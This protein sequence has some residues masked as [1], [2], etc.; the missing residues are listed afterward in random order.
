LPRLHQRG[1]HGR[2]DRPGAGAAVHRLLL[3]PVPDGAAEPRPAG[4]AAPRARLRPDR[5]PRQRRGGRAPMSETPITYAGA[6]V[7]VEAGDRAVEL[8]KA[9][10]ARATRAEALGGLGGFAG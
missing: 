2:R 3:R 4:Q 7:D 5:G 8:M 9:S 1:G 6:G 10:V